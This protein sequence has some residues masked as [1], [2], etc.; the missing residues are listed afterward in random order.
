MRHFL[1]FAIFL[2]IFTSPATQACNSVNA[3]LADFGAIDVDVAG[4]NYE[5]LGTFTVNCPKGS[6]YAIVTDIPQSHTIIGDGSNPI[7]ILLFVKSRPFGGCLTLDESDNTYLSATSRTSQH[8]KTGT[9]KDESWSYCIRIVNN[10]QDAATINS[11]FTLDVSESG[12]ST[13]IN[14]LTINA[15][16]N[17]NS[18][19]FNSG[20]LTTNFGDLKIELAADLNAYSGGEVFATCQLGQNYLITTDLS[21]NF[22]LL[23]NQGN[24]IYLNLYL[25]KNT[26]SCDNLT[27]TSPQRLSAIVIDSAHHQ[28]VGTGAQQV[29]HVCWQI[30]NPSGDTASVNEQFRLFLT[31]Q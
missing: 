18:C 27:E 29:W 14:N 22:S 15:N 13:Q 23:G 24:P 25:S 16:L 28:Q 12:Q 9:G 17:K 7:S 8:V 30:K 5:K 6:T 20:Q 21:E 4:T 31:G 1:I 3:I 10:A 26:F 11:L 2:L 19:L